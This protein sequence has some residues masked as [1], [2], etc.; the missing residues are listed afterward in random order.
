MRFLIA[1]FILVTGCLGPGPNPPYYSPSGPMPD[2]CDKT[3]T[4]TP[5]ATEILPVDGESQPRPAPSFC[6]EHHEHGDALLVTWFSQR[7]QRQELAVGADHPT[8]FRL[9]GGG[10]QD[11]KQP[12][13][14][15]S[16]YEVVSAD[17]SLTPGDRFEFCRVESGNA[18]ITILHVPA[19]ARVHAAEYL[20]I[21]KHAWC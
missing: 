6:W 13:G 2:V 12:T 8:K 5:T 21:E 17:G 9:N 15:G 3:M 18:T 4:P 10:A 16:F 14:G 19:N 20:Q 1:S 11:A 7:I